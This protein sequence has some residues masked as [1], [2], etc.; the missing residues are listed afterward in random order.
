LCPFS[1]GAYKTLLEGVD[2]EVREEG[3]AEKWGKK[4]VVIYDVI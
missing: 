4:C 1:Y 3:E 2:V